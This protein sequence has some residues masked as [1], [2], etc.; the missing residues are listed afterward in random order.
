MKSFTQLSDSDGGR[1]NSI[2]QL[3]YFSN[4]TSIDTSQKNQ[5]KQTK[6]YPATKEQIQEQFS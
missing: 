1:G 2:T 5:H 4:Y 6:F 3:F